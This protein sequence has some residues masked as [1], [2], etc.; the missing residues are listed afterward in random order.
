[1]E[2]WFKFLERSWRSTGQH[3]DE[4][5]S[6]VMCMNPVIN[7]L[8]AVYSPDLAIYGLNASYGEGAGLISVAF[9]RGKI[10]S[11]KSIFSDFI[12]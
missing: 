6:L 11:I 10:L 9:L 7:K 4:P 2:I 12:D 3:V 1:M 8:T 5:C